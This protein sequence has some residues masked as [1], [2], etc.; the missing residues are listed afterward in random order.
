VSINGIVSKKAV[1]EAGADWGVKTVIGTGPFK[2]VEWLPG[3]KITFDRHAEYFKSGLPYL[4]RVELYLNVPEEA[5]VLRW[6]SGEAEYVDYFDGVQAGE[7]PRILSDPKLA[8]LVRMIPSSIFDYVAIASNV[9]PFTDVR[10]RQAIAMALDKQALADSTGIGASVPMDDVYTE[11]LPMFLPGF[12][13]NYQYDPEA[14]KQLMVEAGFADGIK[15]VDMYVD[16][17]PYQG[18]I[19]QADLAKIGIE[20]NVLDGEPDLYQDKLDS[21]EIPLVFSG[22]GADP[23]D[24]DTFVSYALGCGGGAPPSRSLYCTEE[25]QQLYDQ[26]NEL[27]LSDPKRNEL[28]QRIQEIV[29]NESVYLIPVYRRNVLGL[30]QSYVKNEYQFDTLPALE[31]A[32]MEQ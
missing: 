17:H 12:A 21:G 1:E 11:L 9:E 7:L 10:V 5:R 23:P 24:G 2:L 13:S 28:F 31:T 26:S 22:I 15:G 8:P 3:D 29:V 18:A 16:F 30:G 14:A 32:Y 19:V 6:E 25:I 4:D 20:V 27:L